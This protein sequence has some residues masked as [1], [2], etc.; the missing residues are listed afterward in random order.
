M[1]APFR[2][3]AVARSGWNPGAASEVDFQTKGRD[4]A[5]ELRRW[6]EGQIFDVVAASELGEEMGA[7]LEGRFE[8]ACGDERYELGAGSGI[9]VPENE[10]R[11]WR[12]LSD[13]V[14][15]RVRKQ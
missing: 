11:T 12:A 4:L 10:P 5:V 14:L 3:C 7:V 2:A 8:L 13:G 9:L 1:N 15:Y 6:S